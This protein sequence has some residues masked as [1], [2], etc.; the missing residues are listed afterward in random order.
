MEDTEKK[1]FCCTRI[2]QLNWLDSLVLFPLQKT[3]ET[4]H[5]YNTTKYETKS[6]GYRAFFRRS[7]QHTAQWLGK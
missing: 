3:Q 1:W 7:P 4:R 5:V 6:E 2:G